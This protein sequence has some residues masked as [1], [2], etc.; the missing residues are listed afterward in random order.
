MLR[1]LMNW[2]GYPE[3]QAWI[4]ADMARYASLSGKLE[5]ALS[6]SEQ[7]QQVAE[8]CENR[9]E[10]YLRRIDHAR[11]LIQAGRYREALSRLPDP[12]GRSPG[13]QVVVMLV[14]A[15]AHVLQGNHSEGQ[16]WLQQVQALIEG[17]AI[18]H[19]H[20]KFAI[21]SAKF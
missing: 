17:H 19:L 10:P 9:S 7:A 12:G 20:P 11:I 16:D 2:N 18:V 6:L 8:R 13:D 4:L 21:L 3:Y 14:Q 15:E 1:P 5:T